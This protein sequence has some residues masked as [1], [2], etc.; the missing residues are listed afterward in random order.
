MYDVLSVERESGN[1]TE[2]TRKKRQNK[3]K[4][5]K[6]KKKHVWLSERL[7]IEG[8]LNEGPRLQRKHRDEKRSKTKQT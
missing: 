1:G 7:H 2:N 6:N 8:Q 4:M 5:K 3:Q